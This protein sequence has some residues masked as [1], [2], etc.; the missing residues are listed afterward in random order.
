MT[1]KHFARIAAVLAETR[2][3]RRYPDAYAA[4]E[5][6]VLRMASM[7][8]EFNERFDTSRFIAACESQAEVQACHA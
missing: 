4:W 5:V 2:P 1:R 8:Q 3:D 6:T 7:C